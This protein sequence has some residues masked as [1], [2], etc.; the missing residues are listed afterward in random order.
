[1]RLSSAM[2][3]M[4][5]KLCETL[6]SARAFLLQQSSLSSTSLPAHLTGRVSGSL[7]VAGSAESSRDVGA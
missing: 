2:D 4:L 6:R 7:N 3:D 5:R 1:M